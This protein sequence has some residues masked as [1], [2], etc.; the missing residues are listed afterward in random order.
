MKLS[1]LSSSIDS[2]LTLTITAKE[3]TPGDGWTDSAALVP[4]FPDHAKEAEGSSLPIDPIN[5]RNQRHEESG[6]T[7]NGEV[8][9]TQFMNSHLSVNSN[10]KG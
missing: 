3:P 7:T 2:Y 9:T 1:S 4:T 10:P 6:T 5:R 8:Q